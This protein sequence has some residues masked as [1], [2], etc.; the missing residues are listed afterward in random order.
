MKQ[1]AG[2]RGS[3]MVKKLAAGVGLASV[4]ILLFGFTG[5]VDKESIGEAFKALI[6]AI[7][8]AVGSDLAG[9]AIQ[10]QENKSG[11]D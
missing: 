3:V 6:G 5:L 9:L 4:V 2:F 1:F 10:N 8:A 7:V 11:N